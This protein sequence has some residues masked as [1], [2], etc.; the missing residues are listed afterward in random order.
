VRDR[1]TLLKRLLPLSGG[2]NS[3]VFKTS[4][5]WQPTV[6]RFDSCAG[7]SALDVG[8]LDNSAA[9]GENRFGRRERQ[10]RMNGS[11]IGRDEELSIAAT[12]S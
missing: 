4:E 3:L 8:P 2:R 9:R 5:P 6:G 7:P 11:V 10:A 12:S 1:E